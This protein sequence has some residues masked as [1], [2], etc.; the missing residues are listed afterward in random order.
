FL[1]C[2][3]LT[4]GLSETA[5]YGERGFDLGYLI[6]IMFFWSEQHYL[7]DRDNLLMS[8]D[9]SYYPVDKLKLYSAFLFDDLY[10][11]KLGSDYWGNKWAVQA[12]AHYVDPLNLHGLSITAEYVRIEPYVYTHFY[13]INSYT[14]L[15]QFLGYPMQPNSDKILFAADYWFNAKLRLN[16]KFESIRHGANP[17]GENVGGDILLGHRTGDPDTKEFLGGIEDNTLI[18]SGGASYEFIPELFIKLGGRYEKNSFD[19]NENSSYRLIAS[20]SYRYY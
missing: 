5:I 8:F 7:G 6:P 10:I 3:N 11:D 2:K 16:A 9:V 12:G 17:P 15:E 13:Q 14:Q 18:I 1:P 19:G 4:I 20:V